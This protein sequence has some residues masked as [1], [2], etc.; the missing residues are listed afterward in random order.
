MEAAKKPSSN[1]LPAL[2]I[3]VMTGTH[4][5]ALDE[6]GRVIIPAKLR[7]ALT[8][9]FWMIPDENDNIGLYSK[10]T[11][12]D[13]LA[14]CERMTAQHPEDQDIA[15]AVEKIT[16]GAELMTV[17][18]G[19]RVAVSEILRFHAQLDKE[20]VTVGVL[21]HAV[22]WSRERW[23]A[24]QL[25][26]LQSPEVRR[27]QA[28]MLRAAA[29]SIRKVANDAAEQAQTSEVA[30]PEN[31]IG[32]SALGRGA[33]AATGGNAGSDDAKIASAGNGG[34]SPRVLTLSRLGR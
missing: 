24:A 18:G 13:V 6:K 31:V 19:W 10:A 23:E 16:S 4:F 8:E 1:D 12:L 25:R 22:L 2:E 32:I 27:A 3:P 9:Q 33:A 11:G 29:S 15:D 14:H 26:R 34:R 20:V 7:V 17:E 5:H 28:S 21:N 30:V